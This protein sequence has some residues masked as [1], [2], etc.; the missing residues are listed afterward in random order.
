LQK[1]LASF[2]FTLPLTQALVACVKGDGDDKPDSA[3]AIVRAV[4]AAFAQF[5][6]TPPP[7]PSPNR[8][9]GGFEDTGTICRKA[10]TGASIIALLYNCAGL[11]GPAVLNAAMPN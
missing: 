6:V 1:R 7:A 2:V 3:T 5:D 4:Y 10:G 8:I 11:N 9:Q